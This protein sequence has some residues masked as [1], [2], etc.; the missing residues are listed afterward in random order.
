MVH[1]GFRHDR[2]RDVGRDLHFGPRLGRRRL[3]FL[4]ADG[5]GL[6][7]GAADC[8]FRPDSH[9]LPPAGRLAL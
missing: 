5:R 4:H 2:R 1:G 9:V 6:H 3:V 8:G 7:G